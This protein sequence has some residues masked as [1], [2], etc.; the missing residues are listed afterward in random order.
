MQLLD[1]A[2]S[3]PWPSTRSRAPPQHE[4][5]DLGVLLQASYQRVAPHLTG[6]S[7][8]LHCWGERSGGL[9]GRVVVGCGGGHLDVS[10]GLVVVK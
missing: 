2:A 4:G 3:A 8:D 10:A 5:L 7:S 6:H 9:E 1:P